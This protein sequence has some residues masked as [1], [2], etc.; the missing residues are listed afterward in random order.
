[1]NIQMEKTCRAKV[2]GRVENFQVLSGH[3][4]VF[5]NLKGSEPHTAGISMAASLHRPG[6][7]LSPFSAPIRTPENGGCG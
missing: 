1:M 2:M 5:T 7:S 4:H 3:L 6:G